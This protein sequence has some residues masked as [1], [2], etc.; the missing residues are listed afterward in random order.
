MFCLKH[1]T[2]EELRRYYYLEGH[3][4]KNVKNVNILNG[5]QQDYVGSKINDFI[6]WSDDFGKHKFEL[7]V[8]ENIPK[9]ELEYEKIVKEKQMREKERDEIEL[10]KKQMIWKLVSSLKTTSYLEQIIHI[11]HILK[12]FNIS[13]VEYE[14]ERKKYLADKVYKRNEESKSRVNKIYNDL[15]AY[16]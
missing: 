4:S 13:E 8:K 6:T 16:L 3:I 2:D 10:K 9:M 15:Q 11:K 7:Y 14:T 12:K 1:I 5:I